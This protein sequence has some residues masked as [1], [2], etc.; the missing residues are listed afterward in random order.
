MKAHRADT[1]SFL[2]SYEVHVQVITESHIADDR[3]LETSYM[4]LCFLPSQSSVLTPSQAI[5]QFPSEYVSGGEQGAAANTWSPS[6]SAQQWAP[7]SQ[8]GTGTPQKWDGSAAAANS[9]SPSN[10]AQ[11][12]APTNQQATG[13]QQSWS[14][15][16][17]WAP[18]AAA[19]T[20]ARSADMTVDGTPITPKVCFSN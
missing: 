3:F 11:Q 14:P 15:Q 2:E 5:S 9:W 8:Q 6:N 4:S 17:Q 20:Q 16:Q 7:T 10:N 1:V 13:A 12:W 18:Q 19:P